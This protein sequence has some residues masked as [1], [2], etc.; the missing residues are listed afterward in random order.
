MLTQNSSDIWY[1]QLWQ[2]LNEPTPWILII[3]KDPNFIS[4]IGWSVLSTMFFFFKSMLYAMKFDALNMAQDLKNSKFVPP[5]F[6]AWSLHDPRIC[7]D[8]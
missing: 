4:I 2:I 7:F 6:N 1:V 8:K 5:S 3:T